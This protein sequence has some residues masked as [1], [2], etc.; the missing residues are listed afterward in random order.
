MIQESIFKT[1]TTNDVLESL[2]ALNKVNEFSILMN[3]YFRDSYIMTVQDNTT[4][5]TMDPDYIYIKNNKK[6]KIYVKCKYSEYGATNTKN[7]QEFLQVQ[8]ED[9][10]IFQP[11]YKNMNTNWYWICTHEYTDVLLSLMT[12]HCPPL[13]QP[14]RTRINMIEAQGIAPYRMFNQNFKDHHNFTRYN[15]NNKDY[16][17]QFHTNNLC[18]NIFEM[19]EILAKFS[20]EIQQIEISTNMAS[21]N[22]SKEIAFLKQEISKIRNRKVN[23][24]F[25][26]QY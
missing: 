6:V 17:F 16:Q 11:L 3:E 20:N 12:E 23:I 25:N 21:F 7:L 10:I 24:F 22:H 15:T 19:I 9:I 26:N 5:N 2:F 18:I 4:S 8:I 1:P 14:I 13:Y